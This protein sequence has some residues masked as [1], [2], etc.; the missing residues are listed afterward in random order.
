MPHRRAPAKRPI[1]RSVWAIIALTLLLTAAAAMACGGDG[2]RPPTEATPRPTVAPPTAT[3]LRLRY[4]H[5]HSAY[6]HPYSSHSHGYTAY[7]YAHVY[8][9]YPHAHTAAYTNTYAYPAHTYAIPPTPTPTPTPD[10]VSDSAD[11]EALIKLYNATNGP[12]WVNNGNWGTDAPLNEWHGVTTD[13]DGR[14]TGLVLRD[15]GLTN[16]AWGCN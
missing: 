2:G 10:R 6:A 7:A 16:L 11:R 3:P 1:P 14:V 12:R 9:A 4:R 13:R 5:V 15:N 8:S